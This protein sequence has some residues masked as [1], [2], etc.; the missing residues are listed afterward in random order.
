VL[1]VSAHTNPNN[2]IDFRQWPRTPREDDCCPP[3]LFFVKASD[4]LRFT[5]TIFLVDSNTPRI[6]TVELIVFG[7]G[8][9]LIMG[10]GL[11]FLVIL[12]LRRERQASRSTKLQAEQL[13]E[14]KDPID[15]N[16]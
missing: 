3:A 6:V 11:F 8:F 2:R 16:D 4:R 9:G 10:T 15:P 12:P 7:V 14:I 13:L 1:W 5:A